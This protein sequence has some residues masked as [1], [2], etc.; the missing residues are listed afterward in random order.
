MFAPDALTQDAFLNGALKIWQPRK[1]YR[2]GVDPVLLAATVP[3]KSGQSVLELGCGVGVASLCLGRRIS[4]LHLA[5]LE[6]QMPYAEL[7]R[8]N[9]VENNLNFSV[10]D[11]DLRQL[12]Q[13]VRDNRYDHVIANPPYY[14]RS[15]GTG[16]QDT[17]RDVSLAGDTPLDEWIKVAAKRLLPKGY[18]SVI[19]DMRRLPELLTAMETHVGSIEMQ[20]ITGREGR[21][22]NLVIVRGR[23]LGRAAFKSHAPI[24]LHAGQEHERD[25]DD[26]ALNI[27]NVL[28]HG[29]FLPFA[30]D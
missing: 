25:G 9:G 3:V 30:C 12:P 19:Q 29:A 13:D 7:A 2:A 14:L 17:G 22:A 16:S 4:G 11:G 24:A 5:G 23:K 1:G 18:L 21:A 27:S 15:Q 10:Y 20:P 6:L 26:Y 8:R 28:R